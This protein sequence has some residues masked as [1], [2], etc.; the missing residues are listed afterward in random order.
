MEKMFYR[1]SE[2][3]EVLGIGKSLAYR[4][5]AEGKIKSIWLAGCRS[6]RVP[7]EALKQFIDEQSQAQD[8]TKGA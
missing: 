3:A 4:L 7:L 8:G 2:V 5:L 6:R 1:V